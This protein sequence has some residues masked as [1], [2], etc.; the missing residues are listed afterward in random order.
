MASNIIL[1]DPHPRP[2]DLI[3]SPQDKGRLESL[4]K[5]I[6]HEGSPASD[7]HIEIYLPDTIALIG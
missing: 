2:L 4:G 1:L 5:V 3:M 6:W 7:Q